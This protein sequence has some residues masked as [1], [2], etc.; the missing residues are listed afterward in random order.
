MTP[1]NIALE[2]TSYTGCHLGWRREARFRWPD[3]TA[4]TELPLAASSV[5]RT[6]PRTVRASGTPRWLVPHVFSCG[7]AID[8]A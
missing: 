5:R 4:R 6:P 3:R 1:K 7:Q 8:S 2:P